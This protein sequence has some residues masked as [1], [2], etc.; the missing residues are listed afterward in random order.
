M[1]CNAV[2][3]VEWR[4]KE[5]SNVNMRLQIASIHA[6]LSRTSLAPRWHPTWP[7]NM[8]L[9]LSVIRISFVVFL[10]VEKIASPAALKFQC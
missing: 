4:L 9:E 8:T 5:V 3:L 10:C 6:G 1:L 2:T 7:T